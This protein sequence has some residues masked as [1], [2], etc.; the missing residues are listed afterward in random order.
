MEA[1][2]ETRAKDFIERVLKLKCVLPKKANEQFKYIMD[3]EVKWYRNN[4]Y[5]FLI[6]TCPSP[7][8]FS[9]TFETM[10]APNGASRRWQ[11][12]PLRHA[13]R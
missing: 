13:S 2:I 7:N 10:F 9:P 11:I 12:R 1:R 4:F 8:A 3:I 6:N 5:V